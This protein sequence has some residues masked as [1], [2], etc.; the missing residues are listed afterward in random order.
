MWVFANMSIPIIHSGTGAVSSGCVC[1]PSAYT[2]SQICPRFYLLS[3]PYACPLSNRV[4]SNRPDNTLSLL[5]LVLNNLWNVWVFP[6]PW[7]TATWINGP[8]GVVWEIHDY[9]FALVLQNLPFQD[10][11][12]PSIHSSKSK[13]DSGPETG[14]GIVAFFGATVFGFWASLISFDGTSWGVFGKFLAAWT[15]QWPPL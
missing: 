14:Q 12:S 10:L 9:T 7:Y 13:I 11:A 3:H 15:K 4:L 6:F 5:H 8:W 2:V 1:G